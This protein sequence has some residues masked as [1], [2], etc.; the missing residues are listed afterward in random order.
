MP[1][2]AVTGGSGF[3]GRHLLAELRD[4]A[5][6][7]VVAMGRRCPIDWRGEAFVEVDLSVPEAIETA[8]RSIRPEVLFHAAGQTP[9]ANAETLYQANTLNTLHLLDALRAVGSPI[10]MVLAG[11]A[12]ELGLVPVEDLPVGEEYPCRPAEA[13][14]LSKWLATCAGLAARPPLEVMVGRIFNPIG[15][16]LS[17]NQAFGRFAKILAESREK[18][19]VVGDL[20]TR[21]EFVDI[22]DV[23][24]A[25]I[26][27]AE[28]GLAQNTYH[29][30]TGKS[31]RIGDG[32]DHLIARSGREIEVRV[33]PALKSA[34]GPRDSRARIAKIVAQ[35]GWTPRISFRQSMDDLWNE[36]AR[37]DGLTL[38][39]S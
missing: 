17:P 33:D 27:I 37:R 12:A 29:I 28:S 8:I 2:W 10:R 6:L 25:L 5:G 31:V 4:K 3:L 7:E 13:Y 18:T 22:R 21:R 19:L 24:R 34:P 26:A 14:G 30:G 1:V 15:P 23:A 35:T 36:R 20:D 39:P 11:S 32:L 16:G 9:P 38:T